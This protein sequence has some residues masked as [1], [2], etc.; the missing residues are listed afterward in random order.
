MTLLSSRRPLF[1]ILITALSLACI[2]ITYKF[3]TRAFPIASVDLKVDRAH[4]LASARDL[5]QTYNW[6]PTNYRQATSFGS[7]S[8]VQTYV[9]LEVGGT[10]AFN[11]MITGTLYSPFTWTVRHFKEGETNETK[12]A[13]KPDGT[14]YEFLETIA[15]SEPGAKLLPVQARTLAEKKAVADWGVNFN[16]Y[17]IVESSQEVRPN[18][19]ADHTFVYERPDV[20]I[21]QGRYRLRLTVTGD[22]LTELVHFIKIPERFSLRYA[23]MRSANMTI[24]TVARIAMSLLYILLGCCIG[25]FLLRRQGWVI[26]KGAALWAL[27]IWILGLFDSVNSLPLSW[28]QYDTAMSAHNFL[29]QY[30]ISSLME[31]LSWLLVFFLSITAAESL[32]RRAFGHH[33]QLWNFW[34]PSVAS[35]LPAFG[36]TVGGYLMISFDF[37]YVTI[38]YAV[39]IAI[40]GWWVPSDPLINP[41][42]LATYLPWFGPIADSLQAGFW[43]ECLF[44]AVPLSCAALIGQ[45]FGKRNAAIAIA[46]VLQAL[47]F[48][49]GHAHYAVQPAYARVIELFLPSLFWGTIYLIY[50]LV[51]VIISHVMYDLI[52]MAMPLFISS[53]AGSWMDQGAVIMWGAIPLLIVLYF[54]FKR[55]AWN[56]LSD[57]DYNKSW[58]PS[59]QQFERSAVSETPIFSLTKKNMLLIAAVG[60]GALLVW[61][62]AT[63]FKQDAPPLRITRTQALENAQQVLAEKNL[64]SSWKT[65]PLIFETV[66]QN[67]RYVWQEGGKEAYRNLI[68]SW[69]LPAPQWMVRVATFTGDL[70]ERAEDRGRSHWSRQD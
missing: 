63:S 29:M 41:N 30:S 18:G 28:M 16:E 50:G 67:N 39:V 25:L 22:K 10:E 17:T 1:W 55:G 33:I 51:P 37:A 23:E 35:S 49:A 65:L 24:R 8:E 31:S 26:W 7:D 20:L 60:V 44:R 52:L 70:E 54:R 64:G 19:R 61:I 11:Q 68:T 12:V 36:R 13:F 27:L 32:T 34:T 58:Q 4:V 45:R 40:L 46:L 69:Y 15:E 5:A 14:P 6:G 48:G 38:F 3:F 53:A 66:D 62:F 2:A 47:V 42:I 59:Q 43:E 9:E 21:G 56:I 57:A